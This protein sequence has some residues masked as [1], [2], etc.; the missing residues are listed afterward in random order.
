MLN[1]H[2]KAVT[3]RPNKS[4]RTK[5]NPLTAALALGLYFMALMAVSHYA[6]RGVSGSNE[7]FFRGNRHSPWPLVAFGM[8]GASIS[9]VSF[10]SVPGY[11]GITQMTYLQMCLGF[12][13]GYLIVAFVLLPIYY[14]MNLT[15][16]YSYLQV[17][18]GTKARKTGAVFFM[19][20]KLTRA[21]ASFY[22]VA[23]ILQ[24]F[25]FQ[26]IGLPF[27]IT[28]LILLLMVW[29]YTQRSGIRTLVYTDT[30]Q[31]FCFLAALVGIIFV[32]ANRMGLSFDGMVE[33]VS[34]SPLSRIFVM[35]NWMDKQAFWKQFLSGIFI[36]IVMTGLDQ[37]MMQKNLTCRNLRDAQKDMCS[38]GISFVPVNL[39]FLVLGVLLYIYSQ[40]H[41]LPIP[42]E[43]DR[44]LPGLV[45]QGNF[46]PVVFFL[47]ILGV[48]AAAFS[49]VD[50]SLTAL[51]T[52]FCIDILEMT[53]K[54]AE[55]KR[56]MKTR[57][58][59]HLGII[60]V[61]IAF[62]FLFRMLNS[63][64]LIDAI[65][66]MASYTYGP[67]LGLFAFGLLTK[68]LP[69]ERF[70]PVVAIL[71]PII[72]YQ[73]SVCVPQYTSYHFGYELLVLNGL[74]TF[75]GLHLLSLRK[76]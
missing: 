31:T 36:V 67:L 63:T 29:L 41:G 8:I 59:V 32:I 57:R 12:F 4:T 50:S 54:E 28:V 23:T 24:Q 7:A 11:V 70:I 17:R 65:Y 46:G 38:Y 68:K 30:L 76:G 47:F 5:M 43:T 33:T 6:G 26:P 61:F 9:G 39:L 51:T 25:I 44:L 74:L 73:L 3:L 58:K 20:S 42:E 72:R 45:Q 40:Q 35:D 27:G 22:L 37:D 69:R 56:N 62:I 19:L 52:T 18:F 71:S 2:K 66:T 1:H 34:N 48:S 21:G 14:R 60:L 15:S 10:I 55:R 13:F 49:S 75:A 16:I 64:S 53:D